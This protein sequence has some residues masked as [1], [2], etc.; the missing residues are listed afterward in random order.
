MN[1][2]STSVGAAG[3]SRLRRTAWDPSVKN[4]SREIN[5]DARAALSTW[6]AWLSL[7]VLG[8]VGFLAFLDIQ[9]FAVSLQQL[10][11]DLHV[12][13]A[14]FGLL[15][16]ALTGVFG[17]IS[18]VPIGTLADRYDRRLVLACSVLIWSVATV[19][20]GCAH[21]FKVLSAGAIATA[22]G[23]SAL[24]AIIYGMIPELFTPRL[25]PLA[26]TLCYALLVLGSSLAL[27]GAGS[28][29]GI[30]DK[31]KPYWGITES[32]PSWRL[33]FGLAGLLGLPLCALLLV[34]PRKCQRLERS[35][36]ENVA[37]ESML[38]YLRQQGPFV[39]TLM[40]WLAIYR[41]A[42]SAA[43]FWMPTALVRDFDV[44]PRYAG[45]VLGQAGFLGTAA[46]VVIALLVVPRILRALGS[47]IT[48]W[49]AA[50]GCCVAAL[51]GF[52]LMLTRSTA[53]SL[54][55]YAAV[56]GIITITSSVMPGLLQDISRPH[57][58]SRTF[59]MYG[60]ISLGPR[61]LLYYG[62][63]RYS[64][65]GHDLKFSVAIVCG[66]ALLAAAIAFALMVRGYKR[67]LAQLR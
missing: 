6:R 18:S 53:A 55:P 29:L 41:F 42:A 54:P 15:M 67:L 19:I 1:E 8:C 43:Q 56:I 9:V 12:T 39:L 44:S 32:L 47:N 45:L 16:G 13:D 30:I 28:T 35:P 34:V 31:I 49:I 50:T 59:A 48:P 62:V 5:L 24:V 36:P 64:G 10:K 11:I 3:G 17:A 51:A 58:R 38:S 57:L 14:Q 20:C 22:M 33:T 21:D 7:A 61:S 37:G 60:V 26:N 40:F 25:R 23:E 46:G 66:G 63:G 52:S 4:R 27:Y 65:S 2:P